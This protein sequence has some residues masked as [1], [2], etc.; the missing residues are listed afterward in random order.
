MSAH[1]SS[2][3]PSGCLGCVAALLVAGGALAAIGYACREVAAFVLDAG[4]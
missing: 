1:Y 2:R 4:L 3:E